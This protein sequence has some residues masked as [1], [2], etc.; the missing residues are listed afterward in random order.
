MAIQT[1]DQLKWY[2]VRAIS[3]KEKKVKQYIDAEINRL[4]IGNLIPQV[5]IPTEKYYQM[6]DGKKDCER[7]Q[8]FPGICAD[9]AALDGEIEHVIKNI[10]SVIGFWVIRQVMRYR[11]A[12]QKLTVF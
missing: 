7:A 1:S 12:R 4:G 6:R 9:E 3:G 8:F 10:N 5:L 2:V 11:C